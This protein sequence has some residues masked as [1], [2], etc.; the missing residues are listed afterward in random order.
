MDIIMRSITSTDINTIAFLNVR[1]KELKAGYNH[2]L[3]SL[4]QLQTEA[5]ALYDDLLENVQYSSLKKM[6]RI[7]NDLE[8]ACSTFDEFIEN[9]HHNV[10]I[11][12]VATL[13]NNDEYDALP[14][15]I[16]RSK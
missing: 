15:T 6:Y 4:E 10:Y 12:K 13:V 5:N 1:A 11:N 2:S 8:D 3:S 9:Y 16:R 7:I 14:D